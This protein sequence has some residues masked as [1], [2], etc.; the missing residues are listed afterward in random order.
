MTTCYDYKGAMQYL[1]EFIYFIQLSVNIML[2]LL[3][4]YSTFSCRIPA[5]VNIFAVVE[6]LAVTRG[7]GL[8]VQTDKMS[9]SK[10]SSS[11]PHIRGGPTQS[12]NVG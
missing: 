7:R 8:T 1:N 12:K 4:L 2:L 5:L 11:S 6:S 9:A 10:H 3:L